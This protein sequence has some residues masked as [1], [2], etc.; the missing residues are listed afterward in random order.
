MSEE[1]ATHYG[2]G[3]GG[4]GGGLAQKIAESLRRAGKNPDE[5][6]AADL[7]S[8]DEFH[9]RGREATLELARRMRL[10]GESRVLDIGSGLGGTARTLAAE[11][12]CHVV[13]LDLTRAFCEAAATIS[14][15]VNL[16]DH[17]AFQ[18]GDA[19]DPPFADKHFDAA[20][21]I[22]VAMNI[23]AKDKL[24]QEARRVVKPGGIFAVYDILQGE[25]GEA[26]FPAPWARDSSISHLASPDEMQALLS[27]AGFK[28]LEIRDSTEESLAWL[29]ARTQ[30]QG[31]S[32]R[33][34]VT[35]RIL[36]GDD[37]GLMIANQLRGLAERRIRTVSYI[38]E[39]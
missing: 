6:T 7:E 14:D 35:T 20:I 27:G 17:V 29:E 12:G 34:P 22:H 13:G 18:Q 11:Y 24:Y 9:F 25:G 26:L 1:V 21:T 31:R 38:C 5:L 32:A 33:A 39:A 15:W 19:T 4:G 16:G 28:I 8:I 10:S 3:D 2:G 30:R 36:F 37:F 23:E